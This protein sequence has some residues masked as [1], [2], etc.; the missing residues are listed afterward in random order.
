MLRQQVQSVL[1]VQAAALTNNDMLLGLR[2]LLRSSG[3]KSRYL[4]GFKN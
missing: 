2:G 4:N 3:S 1:K